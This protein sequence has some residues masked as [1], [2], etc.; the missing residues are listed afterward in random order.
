[1]V[2]QDETTILNLSLISGEALT[3]ADRRLYNCLLAPALKQ[4]PKQR[5]FTISIKDLDDVYGYGAADIEKVQQS[6]RKL[7]QTSIEF[8]AVTPN[9]SNWNLTPLLDQVKYNS[10]EH[11]LSY[12]FA[13]ECSKILAVPEYFEKHII[14]AHFAY[15]YSSL[16]YDILSGAYFKKQVEYS[17]EVC[18]LRHALGISIDK[19]SNFND[20][21]RYVLEPSLK[22]INAH[23]IFTAGF[24]PQSKGR[25]IIQL[26]FI[27]QN[28]HYVHQ[29]FHARQNVAI[30]FQRLLNQEPQLVKAYAYLVNAKTEERNRLFAIATK[31]ALTKNTFFRDEEVDN[32]ELWF[33]LIKDKV[34]SKL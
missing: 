22:E 10:Q 15:K 2:N 13:E 12:S 29:H 27:L 6:L 11:T 25:K 4:L 19:F 1:M 20:F 30:K 26:D 34:L 18:Q 31:I 5:F 7:T 33:E 24:I 23:A 17:I 8:K 3:L 14:Q 28:K 16:L 9:D 21:K 32:P